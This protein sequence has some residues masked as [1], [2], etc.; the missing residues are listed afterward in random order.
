MKLIYVANVRLPTGKAHGVQI[1]KMCEAFA[2]TGAEV[3]LWA[4]TRHNI[5]KADPFDYFNVR[6]NFKIIK[7]PSLD[8]VR[9]GWL[10][11]WIQ[12]VTFITLSVARALFS[13]ADFFYSRDE[14]FVFLTGLFKKNIYWEVHTNTFNR[15]VGAVAKR[16]IKIIT[17]SSGLK[18]FFMSCGA[19]EKRILVA[20]DGVSLKDFEVSTSKDKIREK[21]GLPNDK[22]VVAYIGKYTT[23]GGKKGVDELIVAVSRLLQKYPNLFLLI[24]GINKSEVLGLEEAMRKENIGKE[25][26]ALTMT[27]PHKDIPMYLKSSDILV[28]NYPSTEH[29]SLYMSPLKMFEYMASGT[30][31]VA[32]DLPSIREVLSEKNAI[33]IQPDNLDSLCEGLEKLIGDASLGKQISGRALEDVKSYGWN[34]RA[35]GILDFIDKK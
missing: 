5:I 20:S 22:F 23:M 7:I 34:E 29:F 4:P 33:L 13:K 11:F 35:G 19:E 9:Y 14:L 16:N 25:N 6:R 32:T 21:L 30:P 28:M 10:G 1:M 2:D 17:I 15:L 8:L 24:V 12:K 26:Y 31:V 27:V 3:E 18:K